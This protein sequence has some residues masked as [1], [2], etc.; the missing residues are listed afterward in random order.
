MSAAKTLAEA[1][2]AGIQTRTQADRRYKT[3]CICSAGAFIPTTRT[4]GFRFI[5]K[6]PVLGITFHTNGSTLNISTDFGD[7]VSTNKGMPANVTNGFTLGNVV[8]AFGLW[9]CGG[10]DTADSNRYKIY[11]APIV[12][13]NG[14]L[15]WT[16][17][18][19]LADGTVGNIAGCINASADGQT[20]CVAEYSITTTV[21][22]APGGPSIYR[23]VNGTAF[24]KV[25]QSA[26]ALARHWHCVRED[27]FNP[28]TWYALLGDGTDSPVWISTNN[29]ASFTP[30]AS[31]PQGWDGVQVD[32]S[33]A[34]VWATGDVYQAGPPV[35]PAYG[36]QRGVLVPQA[37]CDNTF[38]SMP[39]VNSGM[40]QNG[41]VTSG[42]NILTM[43]FVEQLYITSEDEGRRIVIKDKTTGAVV[44]KGT[45][46][47]VSSNLVTLSG[48]A[49]ASTVAGGANYVVDRNE[50]YYP[51]ALQ[52]A[53][54][55]DNEV[56]YLHADNAGAEPPGL[57]Y[58]YGLFAIVNFGGPLIWLD[59]MPSATS[60]V[61]VMGGQ[62]LSGINHRATLKTALSE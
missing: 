20:L 55:P 52:G 30:V 42:S 45:I 14:A 58:R 35:A 12:T 54:D 11:S 61:A 2:K 59:N 10:T 19:T 27:P 5:G 3:R 18:F 46:V 13:G 1:A 16:P 25:A 36:L 8:R 4:G 41:S 44:F 53:V 62:V 9:W 40:Y 47:S 26:I 33:P 39:V 17:R 34:R 48:N 29:A 22:A 24:T 15:T 51:I 56:M 50:R 57:P 49:T 60:Q 6:D 43:T 21:P 7:T 31:V 38:K 28:G 32:F 37:A 23:T